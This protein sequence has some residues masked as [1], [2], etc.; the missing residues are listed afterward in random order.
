MERRPWDHKW[1]IEGVVCK[2]KYTTPGYYYIKF[3]YGALGYFHYWVE[4]EGKKRVGKRGKRRK[5]KRKEK[6]I[7]KK[8]RCLYR[9]PSAPFD[10]K[11]YE[12]QF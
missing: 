1:Q 10:K 12:L 2:A 7:K 6:K 4:T 3:K 11:S 9:K 8:M 5:L